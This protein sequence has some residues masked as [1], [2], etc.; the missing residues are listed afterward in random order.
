MLTAASAIIILVC[1]CYIL[2][3]IYEQ[4][5]F[6]SVAIS[7]WYYAYSTNHKPSRALLGCQISLES[8]PFMMKRFEIFYHD[9]CPYMVFAIWKLQG[10]KEKHIGWA[11]WM[12]S[13]W[14]ISLMNERLGLNMSWFYLYLT[15][16]SK[17]L[18]LFYFIQAMEMATLQ[19]KGN[20]AYCDN[21]SPA[22]TK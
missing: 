1:D 19:S 17:N 16:W 21:P 13:L 8:Q 2:L 11:I 4:Y 6:Y 9:T 18:W 15:I 5:G 22:F 3:Y 12:C 14:L 10:N 20:A 7:L